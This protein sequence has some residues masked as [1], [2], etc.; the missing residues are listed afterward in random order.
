M[1]RW[2]SPSTNRVEL[3]KRKEFEKKSEINKV[4]GGIN[5]RDSGAEIKILLLMVFSVFLLIFSLQWKNTP[6]GKEEGI[7]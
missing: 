7:P 5:I 1:L 4:E 2:V 3:H 6:Y